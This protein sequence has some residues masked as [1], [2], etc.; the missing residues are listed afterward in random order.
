VDCFCG[1]GQSVP[2]FQRRVRSINKRGTIIRGEVERVESL[3]AETSIQSP[4]AER[5]IED[6]R[7]WLEVLAAAVHRRKDAGAQAE[8]AA[9]KLMYEARNR[10]SDAGIRR[11]V[12]ARG[13]VDKQSAAAIL[14]GE[15]NPFA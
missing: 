8:F 15:R 1:C 6:A 5:F 13:W 14:S 2:R 11:P 9:R 3:L 12:A 10:F 4:T 7:Q